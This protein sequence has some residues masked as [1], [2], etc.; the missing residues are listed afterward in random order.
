MSYSFGLSL[1]KVIGYVLIALVVIATGCNKK[2]TDSMT[3][4]VDQRNEAIK[5]AES[6]LGEK[7]AV[8]PSED[9]TY[10]L[11]IKDRSPKISYAVTDLQSNVILKTQSVRG[12]VEWHDTHSIIV[13][14][15]PGVVQ[16]KRKKPTSNQRII[17]LK[18]KI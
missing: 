7:S 5:F 17:E 11:C 6:Y 1:S 8:I 3:D 2:N 16:D 12:T 4:L 10:F 15:R 14:E 9:G 18:E 13:K